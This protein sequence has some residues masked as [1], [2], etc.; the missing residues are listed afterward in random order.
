M[1]GKIYIHKNKIN[2]KCYVGQT[3]VK[4]ESR[5]GRNGSRYSRNPKFWNAIQKYGWKNFEHI[6]LPTIYKNQEDLNNAEIQMIEELDS[7]HNGYNAS[8]GG[9]FAP[10]SNKETLKKIQGKNHFN[11]GK[12]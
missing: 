9:H 3:T 6:I 8:E 4:P 12:K 1:Q 7:Y 2:G 10:F 11:Y 5:W